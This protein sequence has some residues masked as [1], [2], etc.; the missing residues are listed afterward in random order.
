MKV[1]GIFL[2]RYRN[3]SQLG[4]DIVKK[5]E[6]NHVHVRIKDSWCL[7]SDAVSSLS[8]SGK[9]KEREDEASGR[10]GTCCRTNCF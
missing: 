4:L 5:N 3:M 10:D 8:L 6:I 1:L 2:K 7:L 9:L